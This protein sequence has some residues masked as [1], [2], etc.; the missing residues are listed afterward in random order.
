MRTRK[1]NFAWG[2]LEK[3]LRVPVSRSLFI[4][5]RKW[6]FRVGSPSKKPSGSIPERPYV[7]K[8]C[9][10]ATGSLQAT[11]RRALGPWGNRPSGLLK[12]GGG[13]KYFS[14]TKQ[15]LRLDQAHSST[16]TGSFWISRDRQLPNSSGGIFSGQL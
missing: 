6:A 5:T 2:F 16:D 13:I 1:S 11:F 8:D 10:H 9:G 14:V 12:P 7:C 15:F 3:N 4:K